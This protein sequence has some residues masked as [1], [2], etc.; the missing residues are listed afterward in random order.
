MPNRWLFI[1]RMLEPKLSGFFFPNRAQV[2]IFSL[3]TNL[4]VNHLMGDVYFVEQ[5]DNVLSALLVCMSEV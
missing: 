3:K 1:G 5:A 2:Y 4:M